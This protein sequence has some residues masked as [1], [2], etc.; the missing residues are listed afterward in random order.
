VEPLAI[1]C[2]AAG[3]AWGLTSD[4]IAARWPAHED[5]SVR[6]LDWRTVVVVAFGAIAL[7]AVPIRFAASRAGASGPSSPPAS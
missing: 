5:G 2:G 7:A 1:A 3:A 4:R 6:R